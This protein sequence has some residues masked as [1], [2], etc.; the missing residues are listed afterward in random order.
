MGD[1]GE[2]ADFMEETKIWTS[3]G[4][5]LITRLEFDS[6][7]EACQFVEAITSDIE[8]SEVEEVVLRLQGRYLE[9]DIVSEGSDTHG[10][11][12]TLAE[13]MEEKLSETT[14]S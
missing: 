11:T 8:R 1:T 6:G 10:G 3:A 2:P 9:I 12:L 13:E 7:V 4:G 5:A 14:F